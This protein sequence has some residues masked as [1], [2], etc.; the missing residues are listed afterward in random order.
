MKPFPILLVLPPFLKTNDSFSE[1]FGVLPSFQQ[2]TRQSV[3]SFLFSKSFSYTSSLAASTLTPPETPPTQMNNDDENEENKT[4]GVFN[5]VLVAGFESFNR[6]LYQEAVQLLPPMISTKINLKVFSD[7]EIRL[8]PTSTTLTDDSNSN[9]NVNTNPKFTKAL[10]KADMFIGSLIFDYDDVLAVSQLLTN[11]KGP[12]LCFECATELMEFNHV[13]S[14]SMEPQKMA[15][16]SNAP[17]GPPPVVKA[18]LSKFSSGKEEDKLSGYLKLLKIGPQL[19]QFVPGGKAKDLRTWLEAYRCKYLSDIFFVSIILLRCNV[20]LSFS[21]WHEL[22][23][24]HIPLIILMFFF[25]TKRLES[26]G[27]SKCI[28]YASI[29]ISTLSCTSHPT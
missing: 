5:I 16:G 29:I 23:V 22:F 1:A 26:G 4:E 10:Q 15:D 27:N 11:I 6:N 9:N 19:L 13:G 17:S 25:F 14:F 7:S 8:P 12:R 20:Y 2:S 24:S 28:F 21:A 18:V 3:P